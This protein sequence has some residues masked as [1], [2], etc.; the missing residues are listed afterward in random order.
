VEQPSTEEKKSAPAAAESPRVAAAKAAN[1]ELLGLY[2]EWATKFPNSPYIQLRLGDLN[3]NEHSIS[4]ATS[5]YLKAV[6]LN[7]QF[8]AAYKKLAFYAGFHNNRAKQRE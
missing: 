2:S 7:P 8:K 5:H 3:M 4:V 6:E 1:K